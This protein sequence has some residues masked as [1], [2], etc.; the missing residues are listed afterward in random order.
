MLSIKKNWVVF[1]KPSFASS[2]AVLNYLGNYTH[3]IAINEKRIVSFQNN[4]VTFY[5]TDYRHDGKRKT[6]TLPAIEFIRRFLLH[7]LPHGFMRIRHFGFFANRDR[8]KHINLCRK[9]LGE[10]AVAAKDTL[11]TWWEIVQRTGKN[12]LICPTLRIMDY[13]NLL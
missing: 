8:T 10:Y 7:I 12:P 6:M 3:R 5:Y 4:M 11:A 9:L 2:Q 1:I 13:F